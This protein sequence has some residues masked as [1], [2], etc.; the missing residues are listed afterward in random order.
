M[1]VN[2]CPWTPASLVFFFFFFVGPRGR[3]GVAL[4]PSARFAKNEAKMETGKNIMKGAVW[5]VNLVL[6]LTLLKLAMKERQ[7]QSER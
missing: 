4:R 2:M 1:E 5:L 7:K 3:C 6:R